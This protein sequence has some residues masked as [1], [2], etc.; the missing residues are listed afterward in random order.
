ELVD[1]QELYI[2]SDWMI[3]DYSSTIFDYAHLNKPIFLLN[4]DES[5]YRK[6]IGFNFDIHKLGYFPIANNDEEKLA[7]QIMKL[8][9]I[10][11]SKLIERLMSKDNSLSDIKVVESIIR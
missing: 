7:N 5:E 8:R 10:N 1:I 3:T 4:E 11:Y 2:I 9:K 6:S